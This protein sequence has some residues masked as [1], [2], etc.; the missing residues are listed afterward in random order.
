VSLTAGAVEVADDGGGHTDGVGVGAPAHGHGLA[1]LAERAAALGGRLVVGR[2]PEGGF[3][4][5]VQVP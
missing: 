4:L 1:G 3:L 5:R 2:A